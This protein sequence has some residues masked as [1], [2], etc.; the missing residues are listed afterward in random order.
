MWEPNELGVGP[1]SRASCC[2]RRVVLRPKVGAGTTS[3]MRVSSDSG[4][5]VEL[6][7]DSAQDDPRGDL[8]LFV[9]V[10]RAGFSAEIDTWVQ[11][12]AWFAFTQE[13][14]ILEER[15][16][17]EARL[18]SMSPGEL[19]LVFRSLDRT[20]HVGVEGVVGTRSFDREVTLCFSVFSFDPSQLVTFARQARAL[21][22]AAG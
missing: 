20:G 3:D 1:S 10:R 7:R 21:S 12:T 17:G 9:R 18:E 13:L 5:F 22:A 16:Q 2:A 4:D 11:Q 14:V 15:R 6:E 19:S 8:L